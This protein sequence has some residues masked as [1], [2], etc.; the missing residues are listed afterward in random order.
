M[1]L[2]NG[3]Y[4]LFALWPGVTCYIEDPEKDYIAN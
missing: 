2:F 3:D 4:Q 1:D